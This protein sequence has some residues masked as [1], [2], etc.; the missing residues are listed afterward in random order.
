MSSQPTEALVQR[1][2]S[3]RINDLNR[4]RSPRH[5]CSLEGTSHAVESGQTLSWGAVVNDISEGGV[6]VTLCYPFRP[7]TYLTVEVPLPNGLMRTML[8]RVVH[9]NDRA[10]GTWRLGCEFVK[11]LTESDLDLII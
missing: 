7:G 3:S 6:S 11:P 9:V 2:R 1:V 10:D 5:A 4:R 8:V